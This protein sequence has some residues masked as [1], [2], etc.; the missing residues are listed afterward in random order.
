MHRN[1][2]VSGGRFNGSM[3]IGTAENVAKKLT[4]T[5]TS[6]YF[7]SC[8]IRSRRSNAPSSLLLA[9]QQVESEGPPKTMPNDFKDWKRQ[10]NFIPTQ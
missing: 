5:W 3:G 2:K 4:I 10:F 6:I 1:H 7:D 8:S 9:V